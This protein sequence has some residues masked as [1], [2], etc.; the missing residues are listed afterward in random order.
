VADALIVTGPCGAGKSTVGFECLELLARAAA[1][2]ALVD[3]ELVY[4]HPAPTDDPHN[5][6]VA[7]Q[8]LGALWRIYREEGI[9]RLLL[10]RVLLYPRHVDLVRRAVPDATLQIAWLD[11]PED[12]VAARLAGRERGSA[13]EWHL[14]RA[15]EVRDSGMR[16]AASFLVDGNRPP[17]EV[18]A[19]I[20][21][22][23]GWL[24]SV[25]PDR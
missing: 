11:V 6:R 5:E 18:A 1:P 2:A 23:A 3:A 21:E 9:E 8:A 16:E 13:L 14:R 22:R 20:L 4:L 25:P 7:E 12:V 17:G 24:A 10:A 19:D 15:A